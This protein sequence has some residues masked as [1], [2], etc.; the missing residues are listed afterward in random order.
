MKKADFVEELG[1]TYDLTKKVAEQV[2]DA[3]WE[4]IAKAVKKGDDVVFPYG[5]FVLNKKPAREGRNPKTGEVV[6]IAAKVVPQF[7][8]AKK[9]KDDVAGASAP[10]AAPK[11]K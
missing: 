3:F 1:K 6:K 8:P 7:K 11:K 5:K 2:V 9:F 10:K 4:I